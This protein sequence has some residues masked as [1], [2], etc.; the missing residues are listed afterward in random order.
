MADKDMLP[1]LLRG[2][3]RK[4]WGDGTCQ[5]QGEAIREAAPSAQDRTSRRTRYKRMADELQRKKNRT[6]A[7]ARAKMEPSFRN[8]KRVFG[9]RKRGPQGLEEKTKTICAQPS[10]W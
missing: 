5:G 8:L 9:L 4:L 7:R 2:E 10:D 3:E 6:I 1:E